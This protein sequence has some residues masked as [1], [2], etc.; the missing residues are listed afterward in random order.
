MR[1]FR[2][3]RHRRCALTAMDLDE[4]DAQ[5]ILD[6]D[7]RLRICG[8]HVEKTAL[9]AHAHHYRARRIAEVRQP[10]RGYFSD[11][12]AVV[13][14]QRIVR[15]AAGILEVAVQ[16]YFGLEHTAAAE[17]VDERPQNRERDYQRKEYADSCPMSADLGAHRHAT[18]F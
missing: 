10:H 16:I 11:L 14:H 9:D 1:Q 7:L 15:H 13:H 17:H 6:D 5:E 18:L 8:D 3:L 12:D 2:V 4:F